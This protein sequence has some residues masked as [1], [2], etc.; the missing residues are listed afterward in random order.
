MS[1]IF[2]GSADFCRILIK[3][4][5]K[6]ARINHESSSNGSSPSQLEGRWSPPL[7]LKTALTVGPAN[8]APASGINASL[9]SRLLSHDRISCCST[10]L[11]RA[12]TRPKNVIKMRSYHVNRNFVGIGWGPFHRED[13]D[14]TS[15]VCVCAPPSSDK[16]GRD[17]DKV[18]SPSPAWRRTRSIGDR[19]R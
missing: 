6:F 12:K 19:L 5:R 3:T 16:L 10:A 4:R 1:S 17:E 13:G 2:T 18:Q 8:A 7:G 11:L 15:S 14:N 9:G